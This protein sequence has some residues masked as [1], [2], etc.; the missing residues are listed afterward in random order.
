MLTE[1]E[2]SKFPV[3][4]GETLAYLRFDN[5]AFLNIEKE[6]I[7][8]L[9]IS[10]LGYRAA[11]SF[12]RNGLC[13]WANEEETDEGEIAEKLLQAYSPECISDM[14]AG[15]VMSALP[16]PVLGLKKDS[17]KAPDFSH[18]HFLF[19]D[20]MGKPDGLFWELTMREVMKRWD[21]YAVFM[22]YKRAAV[23]VK[24]YDD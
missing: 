13:C 24:R 9:N 22:G 23:E 21:R 12:L 11:K 3:K 7:D 18:I 16:E 1:V 17:E 2:K 6:G 14:I 19:C 4:I 20:I 10:D 8:F 5:R 15:G